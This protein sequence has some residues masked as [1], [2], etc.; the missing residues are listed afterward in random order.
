MG[1]PHVLVPPG[2]KIGPWT[3]LR[4]TA[5]TFSRR[6]DEEHRYIVRCQC[7]KRVSRRLGNIQRTQSCGCKQVELMLATS[8]Q[9]GKTTKTHGLSKSK[10]YYRYHAMLDRCYR[11]TDKQYPNYGGRGIVVCDRWLDSFQ[12]F[13]D[14]MGEPPPRTF[15]DRI[16][17]NGNYTPENCRWADAKTSATNTRATI[18]VTLDGETMS[19]SEA[20]RRLHRD[21]TVPNSLR[22]SR[23][24]TH[25]QAIDFLA[26]PWARAR[27]GRSCFGRLATKQPD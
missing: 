22:K 15:I 5:S 12:A 6:G 20:C 11:Q 21:G 24:F 16:D 27:T 18:L 3:V 23:G 17:N 13:V 1:K 4:K 26:T 10:M 2:T 9:R 14:D 8:R 7:G 19:V 25:Q